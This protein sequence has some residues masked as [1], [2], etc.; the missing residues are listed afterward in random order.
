MIMKANNFKSI[1]INTAISDDDKKNDQIVLGAYSKIK[2]GKKVIIRTGSGNDI[3][4]VDGYIGRQMSTR[5]WSS[6][7]YLKA[8]LGHGDN[9]MSLQGTPQPFWYTDERGRYEDQFHD[10]VVHYLRFDYSSGTLSYLNNFVDI[11]QIDHKGRV[12]GTT[13]NVKIF[14]G[15]DLKDLILL[16]DSSKTKHDFEEGDEINMSQRTELDH[17]TVIEFNGPNF[18][19]IDLRHVKPSVCTE[20]TIID[21]SDKPAYLSI[22]FDDTKENLE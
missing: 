15:S 13:K 1:N 14:Q 10:N 17:F 8:D 21:L 2:D 7:E 4:N 5:T 22:M 16:G 3:L 12:L 9:V 6:V 11:L 19:V 18:Y 20:F